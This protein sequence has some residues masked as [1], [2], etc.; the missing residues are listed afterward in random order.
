MLTGLMSAATVI[1]DSSKDW[2]TARRNSAL[3]GAGISMEVINRTD[4]DGVSSNHEEYSEGKTFHLCTACIF[5]DNWKSE[6]KKCSQVN[7]SI[8]RLEKLAAQ[9]LALQL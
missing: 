8:H 2:S 3:P 4:I 5:K 7:R 6:R 9:S 1:S